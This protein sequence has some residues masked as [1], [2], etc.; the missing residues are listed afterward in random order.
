M[1]TYHYLW[2][3]LRYQPWIYVG[4]SLLVVICALTFLGEGVLISSFV[5]ALTGQLPGSLTVWSILLL[6]IIFRVVRTALLVTNAVIETTLRHIIGA[7]LRRNLF[8]HILSFPGALALNI[9][10]GEMISYFRDDVAEIVMFVVASVVAWA[11]LLTSLATITIMAGISPLMTLIVFLPFLM[12]FILISLIS[13]RIR[14]YRGASRRA[15]GNI[16]RA[17]REMFQT[18][19]AIQLANAEERVID[20][21]RG[22]NNTRRQAALVERMFTALLQTFS[23]NI[24]NLS[25]GLVLLFVGPLLR[26]G[27]FTLGDFALFISYLVITTTL[28]NILG[29]FLMSYRQAGVSFE[30]MQTVLA[31]A[32]PK[33]LVTHGPVYLRGEYPSVP[34]IITT[35]TDSLERLQASGLTY[36]HPNARAGIENVDLELRRGSFT[37]ITGQVGSGKTTLL[38]VLLGLLPK[39]AGTLYWNNKQVEDPANFFVPPLYAYTPQMPRL[40]SKTLRENILFGATLFTGAVTGCLTPCCSGR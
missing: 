34:P 39:Q 30:R 40:F 5:N 36:H 33:Q 27:R 17:I 25:M 35:G 32:A 2:H 8:T 19:Q 28:L 37:V 24:V 38:R 29:T 3:L 7:L 20:Q 31:G 10:P 22:I 6:F 23:A 9:S 21:F 26:D 13:S 14:T 11:T 18:V 16:T 15:T 4:L 12:I 1:K